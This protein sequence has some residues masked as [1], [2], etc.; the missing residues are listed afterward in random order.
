MGKMYLLRSPVVTRSV[1]GQLLPAI[2]F[3]F[4]IC[5]LPALADDIPHLSGRAAFLPRGENMT[6]WFSGNGTWTDPDKPSLAGGFIPQPLAN[7]SD[8]NIFP[9]IDSR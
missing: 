6:C 1:F 5:P 9:F 4:G 7:T 3:S 2:G 8:E